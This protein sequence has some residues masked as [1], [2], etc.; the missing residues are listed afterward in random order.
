MQGLTH[1]SLCHHLLQRSDDALVM[2]LDYSAQ[3][4]AE[5]HW[6]QSQ[7]VSQLRH[8]RRHL[9]TQINKL[10]LLSR[11]IAMKHTGLEDCDRPH[12]QHEKGSFG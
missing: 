7:R 4:G 5:L 9:H 12:L 1:Q 2:A 3:R 6:Q 11:L 10:R 8:L